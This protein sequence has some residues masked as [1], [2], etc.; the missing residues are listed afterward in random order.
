MEPQGNETIRY[1]HE[2]VMGGIDLLQANCISHRFA[3]HAHEEFVL[4]VFERGAERF[5]TNGRSLTAGAGT[6]LVIPPDVGHTGRAAGAEGWSYRAFYPR[7]DLVREI[8]HDLFGRN[9]RPEDIG[10]G[11]Y[12]SPALFSRLLRAHRRL[13]AP[14]SGLDH[15]VELVEVLGLTLTHALSQTAPKRLGVENRAV[16][17]ARAYIDAY[18]A[19]PIN[20]AEIATEVGLSLPHLMRVFSAQ[21]GVPINVYLTAVRLTHARRMLCSGEDAAHVAAAVGFSDQSHMIRRF[22]EAF[23]VTP[24]QYV[25]DSGKA[26]LARCR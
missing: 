21:A 17:T 4:A 9:A 12:S 11:L 18:Y 13:S 8:C 22:R 24:G 3:R 23:G 5:E 14:A 20:G 1:W 19:D 15:A 26:T 2:P 16:N 10:V 25:R 7:P 6:I